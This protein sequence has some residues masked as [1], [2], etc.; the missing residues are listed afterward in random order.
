MDL[1]TRVK[2]EVILDHCTSGTMGL[3]HL[4]CQL[5][6]DLEW[7]LFFVWF[8]ALD[9]I[10]HFFWRFSDHD[11]PSYPG[12]NPFQSSIKE[13]YVLIDKVVDAFCKKTS[14]DAVIM[15]VSDHGHRRRP[16]KLVNFNELLRREGLLVPR[17]KLKSRLIEEARTLVVRNA[18][19]LGAERLLFRVGDLLPKAGEI[20]KSKLSLDFESSVATVADLAGSTCFGGI[21]L[22]QSAIHEAGLED[23]TVEQRVTDLLLS[24]DDPKTGLKLVKEISLR[25]QIYNGKFADKFPDIFFVLQ[26]DYGVH[27]SIYDALIVSDYGHR[28]VSGGHSPDAVFILSGEGESNSKST[29]EMIDIAPTILDILGVEGDSTMMGQSLIS[30]GCSR[31][32]AD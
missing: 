2:S 32:K 28:L 20:R 30:N 1:P 7:D 26:D 15:I 9:C 25:K 24:L 6:E 12:P 22:N 21:N 27:W 4:G 16:T 3:Q 13:F 17:G 10:E 14:S 18:Q 19:R 8:P 31:E 23:R 5:L 29:G 11:D